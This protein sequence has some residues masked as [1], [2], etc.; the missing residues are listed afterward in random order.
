MANEK[1]Q[2]LLK[3]IQADPTAQERLL[4]LEKAQNEEE[5]VRGVIRAA[6]A[7]GF[8]LT[9]AELKDY[10]EAAAAARRARTD[11]QTNKVQTIEDE[12]LEK[13]AGGNECGLPQ[14]AIEIHDRLCPNPYE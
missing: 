1:I 3:A 4:G 2:E 11:A 13:V 9:E 5:T 7:L 8:D 6:K 10:I 12:T 14:I